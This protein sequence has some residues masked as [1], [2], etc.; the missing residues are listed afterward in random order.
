MR[1]HWTVNI[2]RLGML[3]IKERKQFA[4]GAFVRFSAKLLVILLLGS[5]V[6]FLT[7]TALI[8]HRHIF[9]FVANIPWQ[10]WLIFGVSVIIFWLWWDRRIVEMFFEK[11]GKKR[12]VR[13]MTGWS[14]W[15]STNWGIDNLLYPA[16][17]AWLGLMFGGVVMTVSMIMFNG[18]YLLVYERLKIKNGVDWLG[19]DSV[20]KLRNS[21]VKKMETLGKKTYPNG[22][23][24][25]LAQTLLFIPKRIAKWL[26]TAVNGYGVTPF[27]ILSIFADSFVVAAYFRRGI[28]GRLRS[29]DWTIFL[30][31]TI[32]SNA[33]WSLRSYGVVV[34]IRYFWSLA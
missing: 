6:F 34:I 25:C 24:S 19:M 26:V 33:Y 23:A 7:E 15:V 8:F 32:F 10:M 28:S 14:F 18:V 2:E 17:I 29:I 30:S 1:I 16:T 5:A 4:P 20:D 21:L 12:V 31:S 9:V 22:V 27:V 3:L 13:T 11:S